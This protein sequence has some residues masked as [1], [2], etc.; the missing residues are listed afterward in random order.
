MV[1]RRQPSAVPID[2]LPQLPVPAVDIICAHLHC[3]CDDNLCREAST[4]LEASTSKR[5]QLNMTPLFRVSVDPGW[6]SKITLSYMAQH[7]G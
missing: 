2:A 7:L 6:G 5:F 1:K 4:F 3:P